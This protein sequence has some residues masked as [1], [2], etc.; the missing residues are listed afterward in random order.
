MHVSYTI[1]RGHDLKEQISI[2]LQCFIEFVYIII[3][4]ELFITGL[5]TVAVAEGIDVSASW[6][7]KVKTVVQMIAIGFLIMHWSLQEYVFFEVDNALLWFAVL[8]TI[9]SGVEYIIG[10]AKAFKGK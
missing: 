8:L 1:K 10:F 4:R 5:R 3:V 7:G 9:Y 2:L 6:A